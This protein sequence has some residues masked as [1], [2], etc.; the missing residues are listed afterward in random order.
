MLPKGVRV[1]VVS[2][3]PVST[4]PYGILHAALSHAL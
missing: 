1:N 4:L 2:P 3:G